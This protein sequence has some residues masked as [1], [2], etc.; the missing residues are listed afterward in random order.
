MLNTNAEQI[1][2]QKTKQG[3][4]MLKNREIPHS[5]KS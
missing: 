3:D 5:N 4:Q 2:I 1:D